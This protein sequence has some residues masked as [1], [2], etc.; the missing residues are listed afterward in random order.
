MSSIAKPPLLA[1]PSKISRYGNRVSIVTC[2]Q[3][4]DG[5]GL[6]NPFAVIDQSLK[7]K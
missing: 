3:V 5:L 6:L 4:H 2:A 1:L 7:H